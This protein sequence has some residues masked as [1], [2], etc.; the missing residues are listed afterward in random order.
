MLREEDLLSPEADLSTCT[1]G[2]QRLQQACAWPAWQENTAHQHICCN[3]FTFPAGLSYLEN[4]FLPNR[5]STPWL[6]CVRARVCVA[7]WP[8][9]LRLCVL[10]SVFT[11]TPRGPW[12]HLSS[13]CAHIPQIKTSIPTWQAFSC[14]ANL[15]VAILKFCA[16]FTK[17][18]CVGNPKN[19]FWQCC[20]G[21][22][23][24]SC[25][26]LKR[27]DGKMKRDANM[28]TQKWHYICVC[29]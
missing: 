24:A 22:D 9:N 21:F 17:N 11:H 25:Q 29:I 3:E 4:F 15:K 18:P 23:T 20:F 1:R 16:V 13:H 7:L 12:L 5:I 26:I 14:I 2:R 6:V 8:K 19:Y 28:D 10:H 27:K